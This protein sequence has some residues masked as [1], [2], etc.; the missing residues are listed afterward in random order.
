MWEVTTIR[1][2]ICDNVQVSVHPLE[3]RTLE[4]GDCGY[5]MPHDW[6]MTEEEVDEMRQAEDECQKT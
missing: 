2:L 3:A 1:C 6:A 5:M 4:C